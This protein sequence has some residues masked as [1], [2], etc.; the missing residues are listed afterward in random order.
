MDQLFLSGILMFLFGV[1]FLFFTIMRIIRNEV[2]R[3]DDFIENN[4]KEEKEEVEIKISF[5][6]SIK[7]GIGIYIGFGLA[8]LITFLLFMILGVGITD[9]FVRGIY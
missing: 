8:V 3:R 2:E 4:K 1:V 9:F 5:K 6:E 7:M